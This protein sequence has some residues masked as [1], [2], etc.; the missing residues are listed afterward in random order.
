MWQ[1]NANSN[2]SC[3][4]FP[5]GGILLLFLSQWHLESLANFKGKKCW[6]KGFQW[7]HGSTGV[8]Y[9]HFP[10]EPITLKNG[11]SWN[12]SHLQV[13][14]SLPFSTLQSLTVASDIEELNTKVI[15]QVILSSTQNCLRMSGMKL[16]ILTKEGK[17]YWIWLDQHVLLRKATHEA[18]ATLMCYIWTG[19]CFSKTERAIKWSNMYNCINISLNTDALEH[20]YLN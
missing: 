7:A 2:A 11:I 16:P 20:I 14:S 10:S 15:G 17:S 18:C 12:C 13:D 8:F 19:G 5:H 4:Y 3:I 6:I 1:W 9:T